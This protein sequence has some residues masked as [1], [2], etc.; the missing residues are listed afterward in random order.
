SY[1]GTNGS[2]VMN[3]TS[4]ES[5]PHD[6]GRVSE[7]CT[8]SVPP[9]AR[10]CEPSSAGVA[11]ASQPRVSVTR[12]A[13]GV[14]KLP[15]LESEKSTVVVVCGWDAASSGQAPTELNRDASPK[16]ARAPHPPSPHPG[17]TT[18]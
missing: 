4:D 18:A 15:W 13:N 5:P 2:W 14:S 11:P 6:G 3:R 1:P 8:V 12:Q 17:D 10:V 16:V 9:A 7:A